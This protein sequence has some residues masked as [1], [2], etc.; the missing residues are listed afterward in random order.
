MAGDDLTPENPDDTAV[1][2]S[3]PVD[4]APDPAPEPTPEP[5]PAAA[6]R[7]TDRVWSF[8]AMIAV[9]LAALV[10]G[11]GV[12]SAIAAVSNGD[13]QPGRDRHHRFSVNDGRGPELRPGERPFLE[14]GPGLRDGELK[15]LRKKMRTE[16]KER[17]KEFL[18]QRRDADPDA[19]APAD[20]STDAP[21]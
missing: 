6:P 16:M 7:F 2:P 12:G 4:P 19:T 21:G 13:D 1:D 8:R 15:E 10:L 3:V 9:A 5:T 14:R 20:P 11:G 18:E 17:R